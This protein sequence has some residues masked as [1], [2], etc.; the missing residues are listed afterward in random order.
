MIKALVITKHFSQQ[1]G[2][3]P[4]SIRLLATK[5]A[6]FV[7][8]D[9][10]TPE[11]VFIDVGKLKSLPLSENIGIVT[12]PGTSYAVILV[13]G[14]WQNPAFLWKSLHKFGHGSVP[15]VYLPRGGLCKNEFLGR[16]R[17]FKKYIYFYIFEIWIIR[18]SN[19]I[20]YSSQ[21]E[22]LSSEVLVQ[23]GISLII[24]D[25]VNEQNHS[26]SEIELQTNKLLPE[27]KY[28]SRR[29]GMI[30]EIHP[31]KGLMEAIK[32]MALLS[33]VHEK[34]ELFVA[35]GARE[36]AKVYF[37]EIQAIAGDN[38][39]FLGPINHELR[40]L[41]ISHLDL[42]VVPSV[43]ESFGLVCAEALF[44]KCPI[45]TGNHIGFLEIAENA[46]VNV[47]TFEE[48]SAPEIAAKISGDIPAITD[49][50]VERLME[51]NE[52]SLQKYRQLLISLAE[53][54]SVVEESLKNLA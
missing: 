17:G 14:P 15:V 10:I 43:F 36:T 49:E 16:Y 18:K 9:V 24:P 50:C 40:S 31:R 44:Q 12:R 4:E 28:K 11:G 51:M 8:F 32:A 20:I 23:R 33:D 7:Q 30:C 46:G 52:I 27:R 48:I 54:S 53:K 41:F 47:P 6:K 1:H 13:V 29:I 21:L 25:V 5:L 38:V 39:H 22:K 37:K 2:G 45:I 3:A 26:K 34:Y 35:G 19:A 42:I